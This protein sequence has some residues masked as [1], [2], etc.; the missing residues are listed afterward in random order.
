MMGLLLVGV[1]GSTK[2]LELEMHESNIDSVLKDGMLCV[3]STLPSSSKGCK[4]QLILGL[5]LDLHRRYLALSI[6]AQ[7]GTGTY[8]S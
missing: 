1:S 2:D 8:V 4:Y 7:D 3:L 6:L 5:V